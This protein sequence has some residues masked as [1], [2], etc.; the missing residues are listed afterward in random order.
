MS[1]TL[2]YLRYRLRHSIPRGNGGKLLLTLLLVLALPAGIVLVRQIQNYKTN[3]V[4]DTASIYFSP[5]SQNL[6]PDSNFKIMTDM[7]TNQVG[8]V[9]VEFT[10]DPTKVNL[11]SEITVTSRLATIVQKSTMADVNSSGTGIIVAALSTTDRGNPLTG[12]N[13]IANFNVHVVST[14]ANATGTLSITN[15]GVQLIDMQSLV[16][17]FTSSTASL[18]LNVASPSSTG[19]GI[20]SVTGT[21]AITNTPT[22]LITST[23]TSTPTFTPTLTSTK[24]PTPTQVVATN[25]LTPTATGTTAPTATAAPKPGDANGD[26]L[27]NITD[28]GIVVDA[29]GTLPP[30]DPRADL[31]KDGFVN[32]LDVGIIIDNYGK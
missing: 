8:F 7:K 28:I 10:I 18:A 3:A 1:D 27:V 12:I 17:P 24:T 5:S 19:T 13:E 14:Q 26:G 31:N 29:Y 23:V 2:K 9:R 4:L 30:S 22:P 15:S 25:T 6:P 21:I 32:I 16:V 11:S 20:P